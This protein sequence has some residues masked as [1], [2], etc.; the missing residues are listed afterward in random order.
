[1]GTWRDRSVDDEVRHIVC[2]GHAVIHIRSGQ[3]LPVF[4]VN[5]VFEKRLAYTLRQPTMYL[6]INDHRVD[7]VAEIVHSNKFE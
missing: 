1:M 6:S 7:D 3:E 4:I 2:T 5:S